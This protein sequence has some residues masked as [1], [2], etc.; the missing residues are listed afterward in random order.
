MLQYLTL[1]QPN[2]KKNVDYY[3]ASKLFRKEFVVLSC[4]KF[5]RV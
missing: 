4:E 5:T 1:E 3:V 2:S